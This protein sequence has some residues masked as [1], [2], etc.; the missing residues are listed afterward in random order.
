MSST[1]L[2]FESEPTVPPTT[3]EPVVTEESNPPEIHNSATLKQDYNLRTEEPKAVSYR[4]NLPPV[5]RPELTAILSANNNNTNL[6]VE[7]SKFIAWKEVVNDCSENYTAEDLYLKRFHEKGSDFLQG[8]QKPD[9]SLLGMASPKFRSMEGGELKGEMA[10]LRFSKKLGVG[11]VLTIQLPHSGISVTLKPPTERDLIDFYNNIFREKVYLGR[12]SAGLTLTNLSV[13]INNRL[14]EFIVKHIH[15][16]NYTD[17]T[18]DQLRNYLLIHDFHV[19]AW[20]FA[21]TMY[22]N[23]FDYQRPCVSN[24]ETCNHVE[25][26]IIN[27]L[28]LLWVDNSSLTTVQKDILYE[29]RPNKLTTESY[30]K[31]MT[32]HARVT[33][34]EVALTNGIRFKLRVPTFGEYV[35]D[36][37]A[38]VNSINNAI[39]SLITKENEEKEKQEQLTQY[40]SA[41]YLRQY[42]HFIDYIEE[43]F[44]VVNDRDSI[45]AVLE[46]FS[47]D[48][49]VRNEL[50]E[51]ILKFKSD[52]TLAL[53]GIPSFD[54]PKC[55]TPQNNI[56]VSDK[57]VSVIPLDVMMLFFTLLTLRMTK[58]LE[59]A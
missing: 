13:Y 54:C 46:L 33:K 12:M 50:T 56:P 31:Y 23:G 15:S 25:K 34:Q 18:K 7:S 32:E 49:D 43:D 19:L 38:W 11:D 17:I 42:S 6:P 35:A 4:F 10:V 29:I 45:N 36:G 14:F 20:G 27:M 57:L 2:E 9:G 28:K 22:P 1:D 44:G 55:G 8:V 3:V 41:S 40:V 52:T 59:R 37:M 30:R 26:E 21:A 48:D 39:D 53:V 16:L 51:A 5:T 24:L 47:S 58:I